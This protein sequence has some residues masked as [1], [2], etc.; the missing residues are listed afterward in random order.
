MNRILLTVIFL[1]TFLDLGAQ[2]I[3]SIR[4]ELS[5]AGDVEKIRLYYQLGLAYGSLPGD[6]SLHYYK[7][8]LKLAEQKHMDSMAMESAAAIGHALYSRTIPDLQKHSLLALQ[9]AQKLG[10]RNKLGR[11]YTALGDQAFMQGYYYVSLD[12]YRYA[13]AFA[14]EF[15]DQG[16]Y[17][18]ILMGMGMSYSGLDDYSSA[19]NAFQRSLVIEDS[20]KRTSM[21]SN[22]YSEISIVFSKQ[23]KYA[24]ALRYRHLEDSVSVVRKDSS[25]VYLGKINTA[26]LYK[27][28][29]NFKKAIEIYKE[30]VK[31]LTRDSYNKMA[32]YHNFAIALAA[33][34][35][36]SEAMSYFLKSEELNDR[37]VKSDW[38]YV[39]NHREMAGATLL[40]GKTSEALKYAMLSE[41][42]ARESGISS[43][44]YK[45]CILMLSNVYKAMGDMGTAYTYYTKY[46]ALLDSSFQ[47]QRSRNLAE[48]ET[49][50]KLAEK[51][52]QVSALSKENELRKLKAQKENILSAALLAGLGL[53]GLFSFFIV[54][55]YRKTLKQNGLLKEQRVLIDE[56][57]A[58]LAIAG[59][60]KSRF[61]ANISHELR[62]PVTILTGMLELLQDKLSGS[63]EKE[64]LAIAFGNSRKL[65]E[66]IEEM[67]DL[68]RL[69]NAS[70]VFK[71]KQFED[72]VAY[73]EDSLYF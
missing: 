37:L 68:S 45:D 60:M 48:A 54:R 11:Y 47:K 34:K 43:E 13:M 20:M 8:A 40:E 70:P 17:S 61:F 27:N 33:D 71:R 53:A 52:M 4:K 72:Q 1:C 16:L 38:F 51:D 46:A 15:K 6:S 36:F 12:Y 55:A 28:M 66:M 64:K 50:L 31:L 3:A 29:G 69:E 19:L 62:T 41:Q 67:L 21:L 5:R 39:I 25:S 44:E 22:I 63:R 42:M 2:D 65:Q 49:R 73:P 32:L 57:V 18:L 14:E 7:A 35:Q 30:A 23:K 10:L 9:Y 26:I 56:Q 24:E 58:Q 59:N